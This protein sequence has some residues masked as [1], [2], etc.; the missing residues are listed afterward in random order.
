MKTKIVLGI[1]FVLIVLLMM[2]SIS[3]I[4]LISADDTNESIGYANTDFYGYLDN[5]PCDIPPRG[6]TFFYTLIMLSL[7][8]RIE[9]I[10]PLA[11]TPTGEYWGAFEINSYFFCLILLTLVYRFAFWYNFFEKISEKNNWE[12]P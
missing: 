3:T 4:Q 11:I 5:L 7:Y 8:F 10:T 9:I 6:F 1:F 12:L 2:P